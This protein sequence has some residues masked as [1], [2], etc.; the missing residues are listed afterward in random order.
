[1]IR[2]PA[3]I[4]GQGAIIHLLVTQLYPAPSSGIWLVTLVTGNARP[5]AAGLWIYRAFAARFLRG[6]ASVGARCWNR[7]CRG[8]WKSWFDTMQKPVFEGQLDKKCKRCSL[9]LWFDSPRLGSKF[10][11]HAMPQDIPTR[12]FWFADCWILR[13]A[14]MNTIQKRYTLY[15]NIYIL[16]YI[17]IYTYTCMCV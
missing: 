14:D 3:T 6:E 1:M 12:K 10:S 8:N 13:K 16:Y 5:E 9:P 2:V 4:W 15:I 17:Y 11:F 7:K